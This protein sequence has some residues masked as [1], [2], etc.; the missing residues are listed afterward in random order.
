MAV[1]ALLCVV[2]RSALCVT[3]CMVRTAGVMVCGVE[4]LVAMATVLGLYSAIT[5]PRSVGVAVV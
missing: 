1:D 2:V 5:V 3:L 4:L